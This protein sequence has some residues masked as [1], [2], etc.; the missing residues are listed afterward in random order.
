MPGQQLQ[1]GLQGFANARAVGQCAKRQVAACGRGQRPRHHAQRRAR[2]APQRRPLD[3]QQPAQFLRGSGKA[4]ACLVQRL[5]GVHHLLLPA[6]GPVGGLHRGQRAILQMAGTHGLGI[7][8]QAPG[9][10]AQQGQARLVMGL[11]RGPVKAQARQRLTARHGADGAVDAPAVGMA[12]VQALHV[13]RQLLA[14]PAQLR[15]LGGPGL[16]IHLAVR[17]P[18]LLQLA[19]HVELAAFVGVQLQAELAQAHF[20]QAA[21]DHVQRGD[22]L[23]HEEHALVLGQA[24]RDQVGNGLALARARRA[25]E[26]E[27]LAAR[28][29]H[30]GRQLRRVGGQR[31]E[32]LLRRKLLVQPPRVGERRFGAI[33][34]ARRVDQV[35]DHGRVAQLVGA[36]GQVFPHQVLGEGEHGQHHVLA[37]LPAAHILDG[38]AHARP[39]ASDVQP[40]L[41]ARQIACRHAQLQLEVLAQHFHQRGVEARL[42][43]MRLQRE[44][45]ARALALQRD[46]Q[47]DQRRAHAYIGF[48]GPGP[49]QK[50]QGH[51]QGV[52]AAFLQRV[53]CAAKQLHKAAVQLQR[54]QVDEDLAPLQ[55]LFGVRAAQV[56]QAARLVQLLAARVLA[57]HELG[58]GQ[59][60]EHLALGQRVLQRGRGHLQQQRFLAG[61][62]VEQGIAQRQVQQPALPARQPVLGVQLGRGHFAGLRRLQELGR[63]L[64]GEG[65]L[66]LAFTGLGRG[67]LRPGQ[68]QRLDALHARAPHIH[69]QLELVLMLLRQLA[70]TLGNGLA[71][72]HGLA[73]RGQRGLENHQLLQL[74]PLAHGRDVIDHGGREFLLAQPQSHKGMAPR[75]HQQR[76]QVRLLQAGGEQQRQVHA[77]GQPC[78]QH[79]GRTADLLARM[80]EAGRW[81]RIVELFL[82]HGRPDGG[83]QFPGPL[84]TLLVAVDGAGLAPRLQRL[85]GALEDAVHGR[86]VGLHKGR[87]HLGQMPQPAPL[88]ARQQL[89]RVLVAG[90]QHCGLALFGW[91]HVGFAHRGRMD[92]AQLQPQ[93]GG[94]G[95]GQAREQGAVQRHVQIG[96]RIGAVR[97]HRLQAPGARLDEGRFRDQLQA[98]LLQ[99]QIALVDDGQLQQRGH[100]VLEIGEIEFGDGADAQLYGRLRRQGGGGCGIC[101][102][103]S[104]GVFCHAR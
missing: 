55:R 61:L 77:G 47:Q 32:D 54:L 27:I 81:Q 69:Q 57:L 33:G 83:G 76:M 45:R 96:Q 30:H 53:A 37:D 59:Q 7:G 92:T 67:V 13:G 3:A 10:L 56:F 22:F 24:L 70:R 74:E 8:L 29:S 102:G 73:L 16:C 103:I 12:P 50:S 94:L 5:G 90:Q 87:H 88:V 4:P 48:V 51:E 31:A 46:G 41:V 95:L 82:E 23:G 49:D 62:E 104:A 64:H 99:G 9:G 34:L 71:E 42:V 86:V 91:V 65:W 20:A 38:L 97:G 52:G 80:L 68:R 78:I 72:G 25:D 36:L 66:G 15:G 93:H 2:L 58:A 17:V 100:G 84:R 101:G 19:Q 39:D 1:A 11:G 28:G 60:L 89:Q 63:R 44:A 35:G 6:H 43:L 26:H 18:G 40:G 98:Q 75:E 21:V 14:Q 85:G 79:L